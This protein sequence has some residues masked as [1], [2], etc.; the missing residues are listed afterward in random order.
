MGTRAMV[1]NGGAPKK[2]SSEQG[3]KKLENRKITKNNKKDRSKVLTLYLSPFCHEN[4]HRP[5]LSWH[6]GSGAQ[7]AKLDPKFDPLRVE[8]SIFSQRIRD[9]RPQIRR[10]TC[11]TQFFWIF[12]RKFPK[13][14]P[15]ANDAPKKH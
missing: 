13:A 4:S 2:P 14:V 1:P 11:L 12:G 5:P 3:K 8:I 15:L 10:N 7:T 6:H 9:Q